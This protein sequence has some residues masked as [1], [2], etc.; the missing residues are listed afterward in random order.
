MLSKNK[1]RSYKG[2]FFFIYYL[3]LFKRVILIFYMIKFFLKFKDIDF[4]FVL[5]DIIIFKE[6]LI[7]V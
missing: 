5:K 3:N 4:L 6:F 7:E 2:G 1:E